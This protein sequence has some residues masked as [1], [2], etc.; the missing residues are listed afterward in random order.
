MSSYTL[1]RDA[2][3]V[4]EDALGDRKKA[5]TF[6][7]AMALSLV[8]IYCLRC[9]VSHETSVHKLRISICDDKLGLAGPY[10]LAYAVIPAPFWI[11]LQ[12]GRANIL[13]VR[14]L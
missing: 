4:L 12:F 6:A 11:L 10:R 14:L 13:S 3:E 8:L 7:R 2:F 5:E 1:P 9:S